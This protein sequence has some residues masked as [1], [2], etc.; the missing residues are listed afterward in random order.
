VLAVV[1]S[2]RGYAVAVVVG[3]INAALAAFIVLASAMSQW[4]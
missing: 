2:K 1:R 4:D 3:T